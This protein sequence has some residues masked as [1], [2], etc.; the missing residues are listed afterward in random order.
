MHNTEGKAQQQGDTYLFYPPIWAKTHGVSTVQIVVTL[1]LWRRED[2]RHE[3]ISIGQT[4]G[5]DREKI[6]RRGVTCKS[7]RRECTTPA[8]GAGSAHL[9]RLD[10]ASAH[11]VKTVALFRLSRPPI[12]TDQRFAELAEVRLHFGR[13]NGPSTS[14]K[15]RTRRRRLEKR[16]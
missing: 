5:I 3:K 12:L 4:N 15:R 8:P 7:T 2:A 14:E 11:D 6:P 13:T 9:R 1:E 10:L 16:K